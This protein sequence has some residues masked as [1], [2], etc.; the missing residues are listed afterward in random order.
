VKDATK[1]FY[2][3]TAEAFD[4][5]IEEQKTTRTEVC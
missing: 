4:V 1:M 2:P 3:T 5:V